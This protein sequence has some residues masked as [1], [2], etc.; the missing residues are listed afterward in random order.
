MKKTEGR[1][2]RGTVTL[3][4]LNS[5]NS[6]SCYLFW[7]VYTVL[8]GLIVQNTYSTTYLFTCSTCSSCRHFQSVFLFLRAFMFLVHYSTYCIGACKY[9][10]FSQSA[11]LACPQC[12]AISVYFFFLQ[13]ILRSRSRVNIFPKT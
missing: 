11:V 10:R 1:K 2:S 13:P 3:R 6:K 9:S 12:C 4:R 8:N 5:E 7:E